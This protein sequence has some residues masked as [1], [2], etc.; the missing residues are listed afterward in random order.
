MSDDM[1]PF[2]VHQ[3]VFNRAHPPISVTPVHESSSKAA[4]VALDTFMQSVTTT[5]VGIAAAYTRCTLSAL[6]FATNEH[7]YLLKL[8]T[9]R[10][11]AKRPKPQG[12]Y[13][14][15]EALSKT[16]LCQAELRKLGFGLDRLVTSLYLDVDLR[17]KGGA[18]VFAL[19]PQKKKGR[20]SL[21]CIAQVLGG[22]SAVV[23]RDKLAPTFTSEEFDSKNMA[24]LALRAWVSFR[25]GTTS[26][27]LQRLDGVPVYDTQILPDTVSRLRFL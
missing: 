24:N 10:K 19:A 8:S 2:F 4:R 20:G 15:R 13:P 6:A 1:K 3:N 11:Q 21:D 16:L 25:A 17:I 18:D 14:V 7:V 12:H 23:P 9:S 26:T 22:W 27:A 5:A